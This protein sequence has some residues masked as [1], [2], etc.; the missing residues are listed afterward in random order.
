MHLLYYSNL[1]LGMYN[2]KRN[3]LMLRYSSF[4]ELVVAKIVVESVVSDFIENWCRKNSLKS[5]CIIKISMNISEKHKI[6][7]LSVKRQKETRKPC[8]CKVFW[9]LFASYSHS[10][11]A[12]GLLVISYTIL[13]MCFTSFTILMLT[14]SSTL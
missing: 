6:S 5:H 2:D 13:F 14:L 11:V 8:V 3:Q 1:L 9:F 4:N 7:H 10:I 12:G